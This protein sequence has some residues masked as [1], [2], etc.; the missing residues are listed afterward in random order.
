[1]LTHLLDT[2]VYSQRLRPKPLPSVVAKWSEF[3]DSALAISAVCE[4]EIQ[5]GLAK[6]NSERLWTEYREYLEN[7]LVLLPMDKPVSDHFGQLKTQM[8]QL[9]Q[10][11]ADF[12]LLIASTAIVHGL[13]LVTLNHRHF[14]GIPDLKMDLW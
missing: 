4:A 7:R 5:Y 8:E 6:K 13:H 9:G 14:E 3:G 1:M 2:S 12:D 11:R 10:P